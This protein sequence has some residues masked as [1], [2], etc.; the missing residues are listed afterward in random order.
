MRLR[1]TIDFLGLWESINNPQFKS[2]EFDA[3][4]SEAGTNSFTLTPKQWIERTGAIGLI[5]KAGRYGGTYAHKDIHKRYELLKQLAESQLM[6][7]NAVD[8]E[9][10][11]RAISNGKSLP[12]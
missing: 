10:K 2:I 9:K 3:F 4:K 6:H 11:F 7:L 1:S 5:S 8:A 12:E